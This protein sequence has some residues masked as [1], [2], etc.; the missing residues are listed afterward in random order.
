[1]LPKTKFEQ[2][3]AQRILRENFNTLRKLSVGQI[4]HLF[5]VNTNHS[6]GMMTLKIYQKGIRNHTQSIL[7]RQLTEV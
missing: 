5:L 1:M 6:E 3:S 7:L 2:Q 4:A